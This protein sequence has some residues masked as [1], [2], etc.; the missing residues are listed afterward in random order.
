MSNYSPRVRLMT[1]EFFDDVDIKKTYAISADRFQDASDFTFVFVGNVDAQKMK[2]LIEK[3]IGSIPSINRKENWKD[4]KIQ[5]K[6]GRTTREI[7][8]EMKDPKAVVYVHY[9]GKY[10][11]EPEN[12]EYL[13][14]IQYILR[15]RFVE[16]IREKE[17]GT[18]GVSVSSSLNSRPVNNYKITMTNLDFL[19]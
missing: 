1:P 8:A 17:G 11:C 5:P 9:F 18:Y 2:P 14:A 12:N 7:T 16:T 13:N 19:L 10:P 6:E 15:M 4:Q 3:Y